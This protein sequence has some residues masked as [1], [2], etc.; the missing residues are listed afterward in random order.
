[1]QSN[2]NHEQLALAQEKFEPVARELDR[3]VRAMEKE[4]G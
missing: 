1:M 3:L 2:A 4:Q